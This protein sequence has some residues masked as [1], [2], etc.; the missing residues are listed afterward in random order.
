MDSSRHLNI[1]NM[2]PQH[3]T[4]SVTSTQPIHKSHTALES[5]HQKITLFQACP[6]YRA[7]QS[8]A[9]QGTSSLPDSPGGDPIWPGAAGRRAGERR[10]RLLVSEH[11]K[12]DVVLGEALDQSRVEERRTRRKHAAPGDSQ[13]REMWSE[14][15]A[16][17]WRCGQRKQPVSGDVVRGDSQ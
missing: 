4:N 9:A 3:P 8:S 12:L 7:R 17:E 2:W 13:R 15:T 14:E 16:S 1:R 5:Q 6:L 10:R 11:L